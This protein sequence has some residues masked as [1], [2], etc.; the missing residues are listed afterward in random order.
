MELIIRN[1]TG[2]HYTFSHTEVGV[3][4]IGAVPQPTASASD[5]ALVPFI[6]Y[7]PSGK[8]D[9]WV[10]FEGNSALADLKQ[11]Y[12]DKDWKRKGMVYDT[13]YD[14]IE[15]NGRALVYNAR[16]DDAT[17]ANITT[18]LTITPADN[19]KLYV[20]PTGK[21][22]QT[23]PDDSVVVKE[24]T[25][26]TYTFA[27][28]F[29]SL[30]GCNSKEAVELGVKALAKMSNPA[31]AVIPM[32]S[33]TYVGRSKYGN[34]IEIYL[35]KTAN[36]L[37]S[38]SLYGT[39]IYD[40]NIQKT[41]AEYTTT[42]AL[43]V[44]SNS[45]P[46]NIGDVI[47]RFDK[48]RNIKASTYE[49]F[50]EE[51]FNA[52]FID[53]LGNITAQIKTL[54][55]RTI[56]ELQA[57]Y[58]FV[59]SI[60][61]I[62]ENDDTDVPA[63]NIINPFGITNVP[64][65]NAIFKFQEDRAYSIKLDNGSDGLLSKMKRFDYNF[66][67][68]AGLAGDDTPVTRRPLIEIMKDMYDGVTTKSIYDPELFPVDYILDM[69]FPLEVKSSIDGFV[70]KRLDVAY[71]RQYLSSLK[72]F[73][74]LETQYTASYGDAMNIIHLVKSYE[75]YIASERKSYRI[76]LVKGF[77][78]E[79]VKW[80]NNG[81]KGTLAGMTIDGVEDDDTM[82]PKLDTP[83]QMQWLFDKNINTVVKTKNGW[84]M[85]GQDG[86]LKGL[87]HPAKLAFNILITG[88]IM[89][90]ILSEL[91]VN[92]HFLNEPARIAE[93]EAMINSKVISKYRTKIDVTYKCYFSDE[94]AMATG[95]LTDEIRINGS[96]TVKRHDLKI[97]LGNK[98]VSS[99][100]K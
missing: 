94:Y 8:T 35:N 28:I 53:M 55:N 9:A 37:D 25:L 43:G 21:I 22:Y 62:Y 99:S 86:M 42:H 87:E 20:D 27:P 1:S 71:F 47:N 78:K 74:E 11:A 81:L 92:L 65:L 19:V 26:N 14:H 100:S 95:T 40:R 75:S 64:E 10:K 60:R 17:V 96:N 70:K 79:L 46:M 68:E 36:R 80:Y 51:G 49:E 18:M 34:G 29:T 63:I 85:N 67:I 54:I 84:M 6:I 72:T 93:F 45:V 38:I 24:F 50:M 52:L 77:N 23:K 4:V 58:D 16:T 39:A 32:N 76:P 97:L 61:V 15:N 88:R 48:A 31:E 57:L 69:D 73:E 33:F 41:L 2:M 13:L 59:E 44:Y 5:S 98:Y 83:E 91:A 90:D 89:K 82:L 7:S 3:E 56:P 66:T 30:P 12:G